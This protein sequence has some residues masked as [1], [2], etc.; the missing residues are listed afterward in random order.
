MKKSPMPPRKA[1]M[2]ARKSPEQRKRDRERKRREFARK[3]HSL[4][5]V[6]YVAQEV[7]CAVPT[8]RWYTDSNNDN[9]HIETGGMGRKA[10]YT[11]VIPLC[12]KHHRELHA[13]QPERF[14]LAHSFSLEEAAAQTDRSWSTY[15]ADIVERAKKDGR[16]QR[17]VEWRKEN[18]A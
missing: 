14:Q 7:C 13:L 16:F 2:G 12:R 15:G 4:E 18:A 10:D 11:K 9:A 3:Y 17:W 8:C 1:R 6:Y 5:R